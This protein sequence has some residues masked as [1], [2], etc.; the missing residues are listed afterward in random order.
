MLAA[1]A[2]L[3]SER[4]LTM[5]RRHSGCAERKCMHRVSRAPADGDGG[6]AMYGGALGCVPT[7]P[8]GGGAPAAADS[9]DARPILKAN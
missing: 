8:P 6:Y 3:D 5:Q 4:L 1:A 9:L 2:H 7:A